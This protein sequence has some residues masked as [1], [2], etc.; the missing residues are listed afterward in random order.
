[1][2]ITI[3]GFIVDLGNYFSINRSGNKVLIMDENNFIHAFPFLDEE[4]AILN[5]NG[6]LEILNEH[7]VKD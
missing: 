2:K 1:M 4:Q 3:S 5:Y 7:Y 6:L